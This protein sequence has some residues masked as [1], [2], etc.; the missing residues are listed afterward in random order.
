MGRGSDAMSGLLNYMSKT[1]NNK[2]FLENLAKE[3]L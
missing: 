2:E 1:K 3:L